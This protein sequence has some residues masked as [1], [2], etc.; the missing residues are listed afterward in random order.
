MQR[1]AL[2][3]TLITAGALGLLVQAC[4]NAPKAGAQLSVKELGAAA[5]TKAPQGSSRYVFDQQSSKV[6]WVGAK[7]TGKHDGSFERFT[8]NIDLVGDS[9]QKGKVSVELDAT[10]LSSDNPKLTKHL[11]SADFFDAAQYPKVR[12][13]S[14]E[15]KPA[16]AAGKYL[17]SGN[18]DLH[19]VSKAVSFP[20][21]IEKKGDGV[22]AEAEFT[23][24]RRDFN[25]NYDGMANDLIKNE[26]SVR[27]S[28]NAKA[29]DS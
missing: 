15:V 18:L 19:G 25:I 7:V 29:G 12:F 13:T 27:L 28:I 2:Y 16:G 22:H 21:T 3:P 24:N 23:F 10:S 8:G 14:T 1:R 9:P 20:A 6:T 26:V 5:D 17:V 4:D 11:K